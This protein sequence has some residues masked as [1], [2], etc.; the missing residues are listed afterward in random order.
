MAIAVV[1]VNTIRGTVTA[2]IIDIAGDSE[3]EGD[4]GVVVISS[5]GSYGGEGWG[6]G[7]GCVHVYIVHMVVKLEIHIWNFDVEL[8][9][10]LLEWD[11]AYKLIQMNVDSLTPLT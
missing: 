6:R 9:S 11:Q 5:V 3:L 8:E 4:P 7:E 10:S 1:S 2:V